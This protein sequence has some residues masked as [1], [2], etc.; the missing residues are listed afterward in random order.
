MKGTWRHELNRTRLD[1]FIEQ[2]MQCRSGGVGAAG[3]KA[4]CLPAFSRLYHEPN[5][6]EL[7]LGMGLSRPCL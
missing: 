2:L 6:E 3:Q 4:E 5:L 7:T 1:I